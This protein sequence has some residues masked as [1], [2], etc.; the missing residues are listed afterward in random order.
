[1]GRILLF[2]TSGFVGLVAVCCLLGVIVGLP[3][4][5]D[6]L[7][8]SVRDAVATEVARQIPDLPGVG[9]EPGIYVITEQSLEASIRENAEGNDAEN[10]EVRITPAG[11]T[12]GVVS[13]GREAVYSGV[14]AAEE[15]RFV[16]REM[17]ASSR[18]FAFILSPDDLGEAIAGAVNQYLDRN[19]L[20]LESL[21]LEPGQMTLTTVAAP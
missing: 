16:M 3:R 12:F 7:R 8:E 17:D 10:W 21:V 14:P 5:R 4:L 20:L 15:G 6:E 18:V 11:V 1:M 9:V 19:G 13:R 2:V